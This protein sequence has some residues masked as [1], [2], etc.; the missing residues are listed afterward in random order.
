MKFYEVKQMTGYHW[1]SLAFF[2]KKNDAEKYMTLYNTKVEIKPVKIFE[3]EF[4]RL[5]DFKDELEKND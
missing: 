2:R 1:S 3:H 5:K 4:T